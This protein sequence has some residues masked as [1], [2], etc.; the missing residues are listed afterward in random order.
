MKSVWLGVMVVVPCL[1]GCGPANHSNKVSDYEQIVTQRKPCGSRE[2]CQR[3]QKSVDDLE[4]ECQEMLKSGFWD[5]RNCESE[6][7][8]VLRVRKI[9]YEQQ[10]SQRSRAC[11]SGSPGADCVALYVE[12]RSYGDD[13]TA[14]HACMASCNRE[15]D[16]VCC[17][18]VRSVREERTAARAANECVSGCEALLQSCI[19]TENCATRS[20]VEQCKK[21]EYDPCVESCR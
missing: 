16:P 7:A 1:L 20:C 5:K 15:K 12:A 17:S 19:T 11:A 6:K 9:N 8:L 4:S 18:Y 2:D 3:L 14:L 21:K 10:R 13:D